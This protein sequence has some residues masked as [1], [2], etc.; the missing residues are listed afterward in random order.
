MVRHQLP[1]HRPRAR[2]RDELLAV[3]H[4]ALRRALR[5]DGGAGDRHDAGDRRAGLLPAARQVRRRGVRGLRPPGP[6]RAAARGLRRGDR[7]PGRAGRDLGA[8]RRALLR[9]GPLRARARR[10]AAGLRGAGQ[11]PRAHPDLRQDLLRPRWR[12][13][14]RAARSPDRGRRARLPSRRRRRRPGHGARGPQERRADRRRGRPR[15]QVAVCRDRR[16]PQRVDQRARTQPRSA[17]RAAR[18]LRRAGRLLLVLAPAHATRPRRRAALRRARLRAALVDGLRQAEGG[19]GCDDRSWAR[20]GTRGNRRRARCERP[21]VGGQA[22]LPSHSQPRRARPGRGAHRQGRHA[23]EPVRGAPGGSGGPPW[24]A[25]VP[26]HDDRV[27]PADGR[28]PPGACPASPGRDRRRGVSAPDPL[29]SRARDP[30]PGGCGPG[31]SRPRRARAQRHGPVLRRA[32][33]G[34][35]LHPERLGAVLRLA[36]CSPADH[37]RRRQSARTR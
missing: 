8:A 11:G 29:R 31:R 30:L 1:L 34:L 7:A 10:A 37:L 20:P 15:G 21:G 24:P 28:D 22:Q 19:R 36:L 35:R 23:T 17:R 9:R 26:D 6:A 3:V 25:A 18:P 4:E 13:L 16:R 33:G 27:L 5:G 14:R 12:R 2:A 32:D